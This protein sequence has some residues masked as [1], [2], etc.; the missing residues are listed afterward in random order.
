MNIFQVSKRIWWKCSAL[1]APTP[2]ACGYNHKLNISGHYEKH[3]VTD[4]W[5]SSV[6]YGLKGNADA[7]RLLVTT[8]SSQ[9]GFSGSHIDTCEAHMICVLD[10]VCVLGVAF[11]QFCTDL[12]E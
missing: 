10:A 4:A 7:D 8:V 11:L 2:K 3:T 5:F 12:P 1:Q 6:P 9:N